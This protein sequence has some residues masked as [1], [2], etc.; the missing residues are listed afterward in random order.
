MTPTEKQQLARQNDIGL[1]SSAIR[2]RAARI[3]AKRSQ[4]DMARECGVSNTVLNN[5]ERGLT[6]PNRA[7][8]QTLWRSYRVDFNFMINGDYAQLPA[9]VQDALFPALAAATSEWDQKE[10]SNR[11]PAGAKQT[12]RRKAAS[13]T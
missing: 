2:L 6:Y 8:L 7:I 12:P 10:D 11:L 9:D 13:T 5:A 1:E 3:V 4:A